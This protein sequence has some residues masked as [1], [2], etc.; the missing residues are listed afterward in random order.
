M[1]WLLQARADHLLLLHWLMLGNMG[2]LLQARA[3]HLLHLHWLML[4]NMG[5]L[6]QARVHHLLHLLWLMLGNIDRLLQACA[7]HLLHLLWLM[8]GNIDRLLQACAYH[9]LHLLWL[10][11]ENM[12]CTNCE[13]CL[14]LAMSRALWF[15]VARK[16]VHVSGNV[17]QFPAKLRKHCPYDAIDHDWSLTRFAQESYGTHAARSDVLVHHV[18]MVAKCPNSPNG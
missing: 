18:L 1:G 15:S 8:L 7:H 11:L 17:K 10:M 16:H 9:L 2:W 13:E 4:G 12:G 14:E 3:H 5:W 6:L